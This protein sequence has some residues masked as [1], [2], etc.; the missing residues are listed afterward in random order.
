MLALALPHLAGIWRA[1]R[2]GW[3]A[4]LTGWVLALCL[5]I[6]TGISLNGALPGVWIVAYTGLLALMYLAGTRWFD[7]APTLWQRPWQ[8]TGAI[9]LGIVALE[10]TYRWPWT[11]IHSQGH[12]AWTSRPAMI[13]GNLLTALL[14]IAAIGAV[15]RKLASLGWTDLDRIIIGLAPVCG[16]AGYAL[17]ASYEFDK[18]AQT[19]FNVYLFVLGLGALIAGIRGN[20]LGTVNAGL[21]ALAALIVARFFD[22]ELTFL[23]R[24]LAFIG[25]GIGFLATNVVMLRRKGAVAQ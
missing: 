10:L 7:A 11:E 18:S 1:N 4:S 9:G 19:L 6:G 17:A 16:V 8:T 2:S 5:C 15:A 24:G 25:I 20:K 13:A 22:S 12:Q 21:V 23:A 3:R 14:A